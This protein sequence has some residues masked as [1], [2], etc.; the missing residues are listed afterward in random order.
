MAGGARAYNGMYWRERTA[1]SATAAHIAANGIPALLWTGWDAPEVTGA[2]EF[3]AAL[4]NTSSHRPA[5]FSSALAIPPPSISPSFPTEPCLRHRRSSHDVRLPKTHPS[6]AAHG[7]S[8][9]RPPSLRRRFRQ[10]RFSGLRPGRLGSDLA[11]GGQSATRPG[12]KEA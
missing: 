9:R 12:Q 10:V 3:Y 1:S 5:G 8:G 7:V 6:G 11:V 4:Q 2:L